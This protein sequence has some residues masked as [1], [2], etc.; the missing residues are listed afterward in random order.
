MNRTTIR[1]FLSLLAVWV[2]A[3]CGGD[4]SSSMASSPEPAAPDPPPPLSKPEGRFVGDV[5]ID[6][7]LYFGDALVTA[8]GAVRLYVGPAGGGSSG[9]MPVGKPASSLQFIGQVHAEGDH[10]VGSGVIIGEMCAALPAER[11]CDEDATAEITL[12]AADDLVGELRVTSSAGEETWRLD[13]GGWNNY[14]KHAA[15]GLGAQ[16]REELAGFAADGDTVITIDEDNRVFFQS[17]SSGCVGNGQVSMHLDGARNVYKVTLAIESCAD[18]FAHLNGD[19]AG[20]ATTSPSDYWNYDVNL[21]AWLS[22][23]EGAAEPRRVDALGCAIGG[24]SA[25]WGGV[26]TKIVRRPDDSARTS[27]NLTV[28]WGMNIAR[29]TLIQFALL[30]ALAPGRLRPRDRKTLRRVVVQ[31]RSLLSSPRSS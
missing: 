15:S 13:L 30:K 22:T 5:S 18:A 29:A 17:P 26:P 10:L 4:D 24:V 9:A 16:Y 12:T 7:Q 14:Y 11:F 19:F 21:R 6:D 27:G 31:R 1:T 25:R 20:F 2:L 23:T 3:G 28:F 8:D